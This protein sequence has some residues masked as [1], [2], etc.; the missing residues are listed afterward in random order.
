[1]DRGNVD[2]SEVYIRLQQKELMFRKN[3][4]MDGALFPRCDPFE[5]VLMVVRELCAGDE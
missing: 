3:K 5:S 2:A 4:A 1:M